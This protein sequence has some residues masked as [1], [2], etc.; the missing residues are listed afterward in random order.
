MLRYCQQNCYIYFL[1]FRKLVNKVNRNKRMLAIQPK[2]G[3][4]IKTNKTSHIQTKNGFC[5]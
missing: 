3:V 2:K 1:Y 5:R 4:S